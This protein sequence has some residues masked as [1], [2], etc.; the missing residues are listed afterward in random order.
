MHLIPMGLEM[1]DRPT[2]RTEE[3]AI[4]ADM[5]QPKLKTWLLRGVIQHVDT[6]PEDL[7]HPGAGRSRRLTLR[8]TLHIALAERLNNAGILPRTASLAALRWSDM[9]HPP[10]TAANGKVIRDGCRPAEL[11]PNGR[12]MFVF[13][14]GLGT[15]DAPVAEVKQVTPSTSAGA[16]FQFGTKSAGEVTVVDLNL[17]DAQVRSRLGLRN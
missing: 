1:L 3:S 8:R 7:R 2:F 15:D 10:R 9:G 6:E 14:H 5:P 12:T 13:F 16:L 17:L 4:A 11:Y